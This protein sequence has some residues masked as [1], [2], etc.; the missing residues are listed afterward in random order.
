[1]NAQSLIVAAVAMFALPASGQI[2]AGPGPVK[3]GKITIN[4]LSPADYRLIGKESLARWIEVGITYETAPE[5]I[6]EL[7]FKFTLLMEGK[8]LDGDLTVRDVR[9]G[10]EHFAVMYVSPKSIQKL[11]DGRPVTP[12]SI[13]NVWVEVNRRGRILGSKAFKNFVQP[14]VPRVSGVLL[15]RHKTPFNPHNRPKRADV[16]SV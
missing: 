2:A 4:A 16:E 7:T 12:A 15:P 8:L 13:G 9:E 1:M 10:K 6:D 5:T 11:T 14:N 3:L